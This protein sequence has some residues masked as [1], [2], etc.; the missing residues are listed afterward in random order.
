M[1]KLIALF[2]FTILLTIQCNKMHAQVTA[3]DFNVIDC[4]GG[5]PHNLFSDLNSGK[6]VII[7]YFMTSCSP[8]ITAGQTLE[9]LK[10]NLISQYPG[11]IKS[12]AFGFTNTYSC[13]TILNWVNTNSITSIPVDSGATQVAYYGGMGMPT[14]IIAAGNNHQLL[15]SP[16]VGFNTSDT[17]QMANN[18]RTFL[19]GPA[20]VFE[21]NNSISDLKLFPNPVNNKLS[22]DFNLS[23]NSDIQIKVTDIS[24]RLISSQNLM[25]KQKGNNLFELN[26][27]EI[28]SGYYT[29]Q[30]Q[31]QRGISSRKISIIH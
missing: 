22:I 1:K 12:Y 11:K 14:I 29:L 4:N 23:D 15:G 10:S 8:C 19:N 3:M 13:S 9:N 5:G 17:T 31:S 24:G 27:T 18:I 16:Y 30:I 2:T 28:E 7:E 26:T 20:S 6:V 21:N 25:N